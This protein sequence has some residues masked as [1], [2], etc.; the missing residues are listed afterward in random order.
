M[1]GG[2]RNWDGSDCMPELA[3]KS[4]GG[5]VNGPQ[6]EEIRSLSGPG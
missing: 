6:R 3:A 5:K 4:W 2:G 1:D